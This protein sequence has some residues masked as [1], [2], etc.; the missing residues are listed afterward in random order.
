MLRTKS[1]KIIFTALKTL[2]IITVR[3]ADMTNGFAVNTRRYS[4]EPSLFSPLI[5]FP[6]VFSSRL[7]SALLMRKTD[8]ALPQ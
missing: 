2:G 8:F 3:K 1:R 6:S 7:S 5:T 4:A